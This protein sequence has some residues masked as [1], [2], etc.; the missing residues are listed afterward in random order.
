MG[1]LP[2]LVMKPARNCLAL[3]LFVLAAACNGV[4]SGAPGDSNENSPFSMIEVGDTVH[5]IGTEPFWSGEVTG[6]TFRYAVPD[7]AKA[8]DSINASGSARAEEITV[9]RFAGRNG[10]SFS[11]SLD[12]KDFVAAVTPSECS[13][14]MSNRVY[15]F[16]AML[17]VRGESRLGCAWTDEHP[18][19]GPKKP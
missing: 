6:S 5:F 1:R 13:D 19:T 18:F 17:Q 2:L 9:T 3:V 15:P 4:G 11:G 14:G 8:D 16:T 12:D 7:K 10:L